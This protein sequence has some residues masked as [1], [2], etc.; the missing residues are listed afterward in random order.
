MSLGGKKITRESVTRNQRSHV[1][2]NRN[3]KYTVPLFMTELMDLNIPSIF[4]K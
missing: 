3:K 2:N 1:S 4:L